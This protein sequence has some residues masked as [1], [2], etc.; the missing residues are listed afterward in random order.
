MA[1]PAMPALFKA[2]MAS[3]AAGKAAGATSF[4]G[5]KGGIGGGAG[6]GL[7]AKGSFMKSRATDHVDHKDI[8]E[9]RDVGKELMMFLIPGAKAA[10]IL[11]EERQKIS[12]ARRVVLSRRGDRSKKYVEFL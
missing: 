1:L 3:G 2:G 9:T 11:S 12:K 10:E 5:M 8:E 6:K 4:A 7:A